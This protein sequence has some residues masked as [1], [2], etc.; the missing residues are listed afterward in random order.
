MSKFDK[1]LDKWTESLLNEQPVPPNQAK[2]GAAQAPVNAAP[3]S[4]APASSA[5]AQSGQQSAPDL[6][7]LDKMDS[8]GLIDALA[9]VLGDQK[10]AQDIAS[11]LAQYVSQT[12]AA[13]NQAQP[14]DATQQQQQATQQQAAAAP[15]QQAPANQQK[16]Y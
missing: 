1:I 2:V 3:A 7:V 12:Q 6:T 15:Q 10:Q 9:G 4:S 13:Q 11:G 14:Q 5:P 16:Q 8:K